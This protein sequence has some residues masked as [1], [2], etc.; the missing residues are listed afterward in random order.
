[1]PVSSSLAWWFSVTHEADEYSCYSSIVSQIDFVWDYFGDMF[2]I[3][4]AMCNMG[5]ALDP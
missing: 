3:F 1:M 2:M 4:V 5:N